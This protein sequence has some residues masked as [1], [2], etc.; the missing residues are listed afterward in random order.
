MDQKVK[1]QQL[2]TKI[3]LSWTGT[4]IIPT[5]Q[6]T[7]S[8]PE[9]NWLSNLA[10]NDNEC[11]GNLDSHVPEKIQ[12]YTTELVALQIRGNISDTIAVNTSILN[13]VNL[14]A[15]VHQQNEAFGPANIV[16][17]KLSING[18]KT[19]IKMNPCQ[20]PESFFSP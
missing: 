7:S 4:E 10:Y 9:K 8:E 12:E 5:E 16:H 20:P 13:Q 2:S 19:L 3:Q 17:L 18:K 1:G 11:P 15:A 14:N 6:F